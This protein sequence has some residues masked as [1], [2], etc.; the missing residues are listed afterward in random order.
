MTFSVFVHNSGSEKKIVYLPEI[1]TCRLSIG[2]RLTTV[3][4]HELSGDQKIRYEIEPKSFVEKQYFCKLPYDLEGP[5]QMETEEINTDGVM[6]AVSPITAPKADSATDQEP[7]QEQDYESLESLFTLYQPYIKNMSAYD[8]MYFLV[9]TDPKKS[10]FQISIK[11]QFFNTDNPAAADHPWLKG[12]HFGY[13][14]TSFWDLSS[15]SAPFD[16]TSYKPEL[17]YLTTN[18][19]KKP[20]WLQGF[21]FQSGLQHESNGRGGELSRSTN[22]FYGKPIFIFY[23]KTSQF[24][25]QIAP[26]LWAYFNNDDD[27]NPDLSDYRGY[28]DLELKFGKADSFVLG[29][30]LRWASEG[31]SVQLDLTSPLNLFFFKNMDIYIHAQYVSAL[32]ESL[33]DYTERTHA[34]RFGLAIV[35]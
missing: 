24:G 11:Y 30:N 27:T 23:D 25:V 6:F 5:V 2:N 12:L 13:T 3:A 34:L 19:R 33:L 14:Q 4:A 35:R 10:K 17:F 1:L 9:G 16:D 32:A 8:P 21:Y 29:S 18:I 31:P 7:S 20:N 22:Y 28:F 26:K 15:D